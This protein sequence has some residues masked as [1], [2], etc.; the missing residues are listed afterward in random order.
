MFV[1]VLIAVVVFVTNM[2]LQK[3]AVVGN[4]DIH[5][6]EF[7]KKS[8]LADGMVTL[9]PFEPVKNT[10]IMLHDYDQTAVKFS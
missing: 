3:H 6:G 7:Y 1:I 5:H 2:L 8:I 9:E 10:F 4:V